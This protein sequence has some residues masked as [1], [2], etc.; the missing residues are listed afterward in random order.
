MKSVD[1]SY[2]VF[3]ICFQ[4]GRFFC[5]APVTSLALL[6]MD[7]ASE[8]EQQLVCGNDLGEVLFLNWRS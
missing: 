8:K 2:R 6:P 7:L 3:C 4:V 5:K 1:T